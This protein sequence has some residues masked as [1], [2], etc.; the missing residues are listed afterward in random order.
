MP[1]T[2]SELRFWID[3]QAFFTARAENNVLA[4]LDWYVVRT[5]RARVKIR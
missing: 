2:I 5:L 4:F 1:H 3:Q